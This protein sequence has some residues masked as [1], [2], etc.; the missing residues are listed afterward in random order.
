MKRICYILCYSVT[1]LTCYYSVQAQ[2]HEWWAENVQWDGI[3]HWSRYITTS[4]GALGP[5]GLP[6]PSLSSGTVLNQ[7]YLAFTGNVHVKEGDP[8]SNPALYGNF[9]LVADKVSFDF[10]WVPIELFNPS[11]EVK[12]ERNVFHEYYNVKHAT[13]DIYLNTRVQLLNRDRIKLALRIGYKF[14]TSNKLGAARFTD[15][16]GY[17]FDLSINHSSNLSSGSRLAW[18]GMLGFYAWQTNKPHLLQ[19]DALLAGIGLRWTVKKWETEGSM[20][21]YVGYMNNGDQPMVL[22]TRTKY[23]IGKVQ[24]L[25][26]L[27]FGLHD[28]PYTSI[29]T[30]VFY[31]L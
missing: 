31:H 10:Y 29:E 12:T 27:Q 25:G 22:L 30:G 8:T 3:T 14:A 1:W 21:T 15:S 9:A 28:Y 2:S 6:I 13:G 18:I 19:D 26:S 11:H 17:Y 24:L 20:R 16:P 7:N 4:A 23:R 5:N